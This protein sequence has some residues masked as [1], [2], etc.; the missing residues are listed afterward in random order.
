MIYSTTTTSSTGWTY[1]EVE[2]TNELNC[3]RI[4]VGICVGYKSSQEL[5]RLASVGLALAA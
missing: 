1:Q 4:S 2:S 5:A 3:P